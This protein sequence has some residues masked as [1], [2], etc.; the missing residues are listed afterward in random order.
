MGANRAKPG[1]RHRGTTRRRPGQRWRDRTEAARRGKE[2]R[3]RNG[4]QRPRQLK[5]YERQHEQ[6]R[7]GKGEGDRENPPLLPSKPGGLP[8][9]RNRMIA[10]LM[11]YP[12]RL[13]SP[14]RL[15]RISARPKHQTDAGT[16]ITPINSKMP[17]AGSA[18]ASDNPW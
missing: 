17:M 14:R 18:P 7:H 12:L 2:S 1:Y 8:L 13:S 11:G 16:R 3:R 5:G 10:A 4:W 6:Q 9:H 15:A